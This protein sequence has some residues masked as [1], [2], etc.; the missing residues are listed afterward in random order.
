MINESNSKMSTQK[1]L[2]TN[3][4]SLKIEDPKK[5][6]KTK[7][8]R[9]RTLIKKCREVADIC[10]LKINL[11]VLDSRFNKIRESYTDKRVSIQSLIDAIEKDKYV[12]KD[13]KLRIISTENKARGDAGDKNSDDDEVADVS[14]GIQL[15]HIASHESTDTQ[16]TKKLDERMRKPAHMMAQHVRGPSLD[17]APLFIVEKVK[18]EKKTVT[19]Q[20]NLNSASDHFESESSIDG[21]DFVR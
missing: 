6:A 3:Q 15:K 11:T 2:T 12:P 19:P 5:L 10:D 14:V 20:V 9:I 1:T 13:Q 17:Q 8:K 16:A 7:W 18:L 4:V 21:L